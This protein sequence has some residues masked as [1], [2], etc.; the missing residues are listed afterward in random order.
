MFWII[1]IAVGGVVL[2]A[3]AVDVTTDQRV[4]AKERA[5][6]A[7]LAETTPEVVVYATLADCQRAATRLG[8]LPSSC[9]PRQ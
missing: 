6:Q 4:A 5:A 3:S 8:M 2:G 9:E 1:P 7:L